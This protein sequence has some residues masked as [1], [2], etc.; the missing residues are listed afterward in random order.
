MSGSAGGGLE[1]R[2]RLM[3]VT[4]PDPA[5]GRPLE[6]VVAEC[7]AA[8]ATAIQ[9]RDKRADART[10]AVQARTLLAPTRAAGA[11]FIVNDRLD[12]ALA[13]GADGVHLGPEDLPIGTARRL[14]PPPFLLGYSTDDPREAAAAARAGADYLGVGAVFGTRS[15][16]GLAGEAIG[17]ERVREVREAAGVPC[18]GIGGVTSLNAHH[19][20][21]TGAGIAVLSAVMDADRPGEVVRRLLAAGGGGRPPGPGGDRM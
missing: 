17:P 9:L 8:G 3:V 6:Q 21:D 20:F 12:V 7:L 14:A 5:C 13:I 10:L 1:A 19:V 15:K 18:V 4:R 2:L 11:L 16:A